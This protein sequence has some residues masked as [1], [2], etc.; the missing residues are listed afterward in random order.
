M[1]RQSHDP[2]SLPS[3]PPHNHQPH[4]SP[5]LFASC[6]RQRPCCGHRSAA[7]AGQLE[8][9]LN[10]A[11]HMCHQLQQPPSTSTAAAAVTPGSNAPPSG[12]TAPVRG[13][14][15]SQEQQ[16]A[17]AGQVLA[18]VCAV[19]SADVKLPR[20]QRLV[21]VREAACRGGG[22]GCS[23]RTTLKRRG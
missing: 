23:T 3:Q 6:M 14:G 20:M 22:S 21:T 17:L 7:C 10:A 2:G 1:Q 18:L 16:R 9:V 8:W 12:I 13:P 4:M 11:Q 5:G 15:R 19:Y